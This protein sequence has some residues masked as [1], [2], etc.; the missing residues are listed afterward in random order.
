MSTLVRNGAL[1][2]AGALIL[3][4]GW[5]DPGLSVGRAVRGVPLAEWAGIAAA[6]L[7]LAALV[8][9]TSL[10][11]RIVAQQGRLLKR[12][13]ELETR[14]GPE[15]SQMLGL[16]VGSEAPAFVLPGLDGR[17]RSLSD[18]LGA[19]CPL[20]LIFSDAACGPCGALIPEVARWQLQ[21]KQ[22]TLAV[23][24]RGSLEEHRADGSAREVRDLLV[25]PE[26]DVAEAYRSPGTP[27]A[28]VVSPDGMIST[29][30]VA[31]GPAIAAL[32]AR[33]SAQLTPGQP[34]FQGLP[35]SNGHPVTND[36]RLT[37]IR[38]ASSICQLTW[39]RRSTSQG[40][41][42]AVNDQN[43][44]RLS[45]AL[46]GEQSSRR[47]FL[48]LLGVGFGRRSGAAI[49][50]DPA[51]AKQCKAD[52]H[53]CKPGGKQKCCSGFCD[54]TTGKCAPPPAATCGNG[55]DCQ[56]ASNFYGC[57]VGQ[58]A[59][60]GFCLPFPS[61]PVCPPRFRPAQC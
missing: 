4:A 8:L 6:S 11:L 3:A 57:C 59:G 23:V 52:G 35:G 32:L 53:H 56:P 9:L 40:R 58:V 33:A 31:G 1:G 54:P 43:F 13:E 5:S 42:V 44:D 49:A 50:V 61:S 55:C 14:L 37:V 46:D 39:W 19:G 60:Q 38:P 30:M 22:L 12:M 15:S 25:E 17:L 2:A 27:T 41:R 47:R 10:V 20:L 36:D 26:R 18:L 45:K 24:S 28:V 48:K 34:S 51:Y 7:V 21:Y 29:E 16:P